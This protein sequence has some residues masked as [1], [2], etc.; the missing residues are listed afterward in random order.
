MTSSVFHIANKGTISGV[1]HLPGD[2][3]I[4]HRAIILGAISNGITQINGFLEAEDC[5]ATLEAFKQMG[6]QIE[7]PIDQK[8]IIHGVGM[9]GL[10]APKAEFYLG[11]SGTSMRLL[12]GLLS[13][14]SFDSVLIG[15]A[16]LMSRPMERIIIPLRQMG[17]TIE[18]SDSGSAPLYIKG[19]QALKGITYTPEITSAQVKS[20]LLLA[21]LYAEGE[22]NIREQSVSRDHTERMLTSFGYPII[23]ADRNV[24][25][26]G[27]GVLNAIDVIIPA[28]LSSAAF[29]IVG[30]LISDNS[31]LII[32]NVGINPTRSG[33]ISI[34]QLMG[35]NIE[36][37]NKRLYGDEPVADIVVSSSVL[38]G[39]QIP[40]D[41]VSIAIDEFPILFIAASVAKGQTI[42]KG[43]KELRVKE[44]DRIASMV[45][46]LQV[47]GINAES[48]EDGAI[49]NGGTLKGGTVDSQGDHR[50]TMAF[51]MAGLVSEQAISITDCSNV[52][53][54]FPSF[55]LLAKQ[56]GLTI[57]EKSK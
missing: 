23:K 37:Q 16:S 9:K 33:V 18:G 44:S 28:D 8:V 51:S 35:A 41:L 5:Q 15:D 3:S 30:A 20:C 24:A 36:L 45:T 31:T 54:S 52:S 38:E 55:V 48:L 46:G 14:Q 57:V 4:S 27:G 42:I 49:I 39:I 19:G 21:G 50:V 34:L 6:V 7:G 25:L 2:K 32:K 1:C 11:N 26:Q 29:F 12:S 17:A 40:Q 13:A 56:L 53:T 43:A 47:L 22:T 10:T